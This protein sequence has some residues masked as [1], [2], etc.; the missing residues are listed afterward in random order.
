MKIEKKTVQSG[1]LKMEKNVQI[2][3]DEDMNVPDTKPDV[4]K[5][6]ESRGEVHL[7][8]LEVL[9]DR[10]RIRGTFL[11]RILYISAEKG[12]EISCMEHEFL[13]EEFM[14]VEGAQ[15]TDTAKVTVDLEDL[16]VS[17]INSRKCGVRSVLFF[18]I[19]ISETKFVD[20]TVGVEKKHMVQCLYESV[21]MTEVVMYKKDIQ[22]IRTDVSLP[23]GKPNIREILWYSIQLRDV[24]VRMMEEK[25]QIRGELFLFLLYRSEDLQDS[26]Q[27]YDWEVPF[28][29]EL[30]CGDSRENLIGNIAVNLGNH[31]TSVKPDA[32]GESRNVEADAV[33][34]L[35]LKAYREFQMPVLKDMYAN[36]R[37][38]RLKTR[39]VEF[40]NL[41]FQ[42]NAKTKISH[43]ISAEGNPYKLLQVL[44]VE[45]SIRIEDFRFEEQGIH[46]EGL[47]FC[48][49]LY[50]A[51]DDGA[52]V[53]SKEVVI[54]FEYLVE[55]QQS[56]PA[57]RCE[58]RGVV[59]QLG[60]YVVDGDQL[61]IRVTAGIYVTGFV[62]V[63]MEMI[64]DA[65]DLP[66]EEEDISRI[67]SITGYLVKTG[68]SLWEI[69]KRYGTT[70]EKIRQYNEEV[71]DPPEPGRTL[72]LMKEME[73]IIGE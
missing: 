68:D 59:E 24:D 20:C 6:V 71:S 34:E 64:D 72:F 54:P 1:I 11:V 10:I 12:R 56:Y 66:R 63:R 16:T 2:T 22:R 25:L 51:G 47:I 67:P 21:P 45:G 27:Y 43:R 36:N 19:H 50:I 9:T 53:Q 58:I 73:G 70:I 15:S 5:I 69:A 57:D 55:T 62:H 44:N 17:V 29:K 42:N 37:K 40:E 60:G 23:A 38:L 28:T 7:D 31:Q 35:D 48:K 33:L 49:V 13:L 41:T 46:T 3:V 32:D 39:P 30:E 61:E 14:N 65:E 26:V 18:H 4:E 8:E 52:P